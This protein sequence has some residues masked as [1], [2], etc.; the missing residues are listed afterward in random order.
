MKI[1]YC[2]A[3]TYNSGGMERVLTNKAN[4]LAALGH[5]VLII[6]TDQQ[7]RK[8]FFTL[9]PVIQYEDLDINY[10]ENNDKGFINKLLHYPWKQRKHQKRLT[11]VL[12]RLKADIVIS[13]FCNDVSF[14][15]NIADGSKKVLEI[16]FSKFKRLQYGR[17]GIWLFADWLRSKMDE[18]IV[19]KFDRFVVLTYEDKGYWG[20][21]PNITVIANAKNE[22]GDHVALLSNKQAIAVGRLDYQKGFE[23]LLEAWLLVHKRF[24]DWKLKIIGDGEMRHHLEI[25]IALYKLDKVVELKKNISDMLSEYLDASLLVLSSRYEGLPMVLLEAMSVGLPLVSY[26][27]KCGPRDLITD[28]ENGFLVSEGKIPELAEKIMR[29]IEN[30]LLRQQM[31]Q[32]AKIKSEQYSE[33]VIMAQWMKLF[34]ELL[35]ERK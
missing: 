23:R 22:W 5:E 26:D 24:P 20:D 12:K 34:D 11:G 1:V 13:M 14:I 30:P 28:G 6:T 2:I 33:P 7:G 8:P 17:K 16:H 18:R 32:A 29:L 4:F 9:S 21:L 3:G 19:R 10:T 27:C 35:S 31:G 15:T 25:M